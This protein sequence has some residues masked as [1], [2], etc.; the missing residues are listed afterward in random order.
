V[1]AYESAD[2]LLAESD[3]RRYLHVVIL[4]AI[5][6]KASRLEIRFAEDGGLLYYREEDR[7]WELSPPPD[8]LYP[9]LKDAVREVSRLVSPERPD[10]QVFAG[11][12]GARYE[13]LECGWLTYHLGGQWL[14]LCVRIDPREPFGGIRFD[15]EG[16]ADFAEAAGEAL[17]E[18]ALKLSSSDL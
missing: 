17:A 15:I 6:D 7:D 12:P 9:L 8:E 5:R 4:N 2:Q 18:Y 11:V 10:V 3:A 16:A 14:D 13:P 1:L